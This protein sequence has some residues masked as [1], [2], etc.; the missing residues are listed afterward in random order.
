MH[1]NKYYLPQPYLIIVQSAFILRNSIK[2]CAMYSF[3]L[4]YLNC[5]GNNI[6][7][8][9]RFPSRLGSITLALST[10]FTVIVHWNYCLKLNWNI[11]LLQLQY[12]WCEENGSHLPSETG[13]WITVSSYKTYAWNKMQ[14]GLIHQHGDRWCKFQILPIH[15]WLLWSCAIL[16]S[17]KVWVCRLLSYR[18]NYC[19]SFLYTFPINLYLI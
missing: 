3:L 11:C 17:V 15:Y 12:F 18:N 6:S 1:I 2:H 10:L 16:L 4:F 9:C 13:S 8:F 14:S 7:H 19:H 5:Q